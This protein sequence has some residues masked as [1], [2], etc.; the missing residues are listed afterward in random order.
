MGNRRVSKEKPE[1]LKV[2]IYIKMKLM[3][4]NTNSISIKLKHKNKNKKSLTSFY[5]YRGDQTGILRIKRKAS[6][7][8]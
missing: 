3:L 4:I 7:Q 6:M 5:K 1:Q 2:K 8:V